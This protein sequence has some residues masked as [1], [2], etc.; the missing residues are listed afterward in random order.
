MGFYQRFPLSFSFQRLRSPDGPASPASG[1][2]SR[3]GGLSGPSWLQSP[4]T[5]AARGPRQAPRRPG[6]EM[7][8]PAHWGYVLG[9]RGRGPDEYEK[10]YSGAFPPQLRAQ[11]RDLA[12]GMFVFGYDNYMAHAFPQDELNPIHCRGLAPA[13]WGRALTRFLSPS[14]LGFSPL[15]SGSLEGARAVGVP[16]S[17]SAPCPP[18]SLVRGGPVAFFS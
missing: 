17:A 7:C 14:A 9:G 18:E 11:M 5:G 10:R 6:P 15:S 1:P 8:G 3:P 2:V 13:A 12:R 4:G 16:G